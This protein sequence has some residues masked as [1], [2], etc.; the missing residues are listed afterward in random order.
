M[1]A[2]PLF[3]SACAEWCTP[4][5]IVELVRVFGKGKIG[6]DPCS[7]KQSI[8]RAAHN[9]TLPTNNGLVEPWAH[10]GLVYVN[11]PYGRDISKWCAKARV[12]AEVG[13][14][15]IIMLV[16]ARTDTTW[17]HKTVPYSKAFCLIAGRL[18]FLGAKYPAPFPSALVYFGKS[19]DS[20]A[21]TFDPLGW[22]VTL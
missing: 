12:E 10:H 9:W 1:V 19:N 21:R 5:N 15:E 11:P 7:N 13:D 20:F 18:T 4:R 17:W 3:S 14:A 16:P 8:V 6:L 2:L 22:V